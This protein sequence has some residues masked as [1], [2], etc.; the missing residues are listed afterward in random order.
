MAEL[1][2]AWLK[3]RRKEAGLTQRDL[4]SVL[5]VDHTYISKT[6]TSTT[7][8]TPGPETLDKIAVV[9][10]LDKDIL[11]RKARRVPPRITT[12]YWAGISDEAHEA[13]KAI[14]RKEGL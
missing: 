13:I 11:Y 10:R 6:E 5:G 12:A 8:G 1:F 7:T 2:G 9:L 3:A 4:A 14:L